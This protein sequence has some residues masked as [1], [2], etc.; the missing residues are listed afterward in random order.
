[1]IIRSK[2]TLLVEPNINK[3]FKMQKFNHIF[4]NSTHSFSLLKG[5]NN[6]QDSW[7]SKDFSADAGFPTVSFEIFFQNYCLSVRITLCLWASI[8][9]GL[10]LQRVRCESQDMESL[11]S[12]CCASGWGDSSS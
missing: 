9:L 11:D 10:L 8:V 7:W 4:A 2:R 12:K 3:I 5:H 6:K 1:M